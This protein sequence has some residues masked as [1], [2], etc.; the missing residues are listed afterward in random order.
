M[1]TASKVLAGI[2]VLFVLVAAIFLGAKSHPTAA[3]ASGASVNRYEAG[4]AW[5]RDGYY[6]GTSQQYSVDSSGNVVTTGTATLSSTLTVGGLVTHDAGTLAS[7]TNSTSSVQTSQTL[8]AS[9]IANYSSVIFTPNVGSITLTLPASSTLSAFLPTAGDWTQQCWLNATSSAGK[10]ITFAAGTGIDLEVA[11]ST[12]TTQGT[13][14]LFIGPG[15]SA[16]FRFI[17]KPATASAFDIAAQL[18]SFIDGD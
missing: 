12:A 13:P 9:D 11:S 6:I 14:G 16:C 10:K 7:Y 8:A 15:D 17:R 4:I 5:T 2:G 18:T 1:N 3:P